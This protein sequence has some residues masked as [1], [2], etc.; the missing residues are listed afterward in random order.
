LPDILLVGKFCPFV[1]PYIFCYHL[2]FFNPSKNSAIPMSTQNPMLKKLLNALDEAQATDIHAMDV[3]DQT[4]VTDFMI[5][6]SGRSSRHVKAIAENTVELMK[7]LGIPA[8]SM[9]GLETGDWVLI[10]FA[11]FIVHVMQ[12]ES[13]AFYHLEGLWEHKP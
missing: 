9:T 6:C 12:P 13:R 11:D 2:A 1:F 3:R 5:V 10:D 8:L 4:T 7:T